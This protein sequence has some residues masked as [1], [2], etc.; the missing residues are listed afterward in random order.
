MKKRERGST[1]IL[2]MIVI[3]VLAMCVAGALDYTLQTFRDAQQTNALNQAIAAGNGA[4]DLAYVQWREAC[5]SQENTAMTAA[6][7]SSWVY[8]PTYS[9]LVGSSATAGSFLNFSGTAVP[10]TVTVSSLNATNPATIN[11]PLPSSAA[12][13]PSQAQSP[14][15]P[16]YSY[17][18]K[19]VVTYQSLTG[20]QTVN[21]CRI[22]EKST[23][24]PW[25]YAIFYNGD[26]EINPGSTFNINGWVQTN[27]SLYT[28]GGG[29]GSNNLDFTN[30]VNY[31]QSWNS[32][33]QWSPSDTDHSGTPTSPS[34]TTKP[35]PGP[36][37]LPENA[38]L[39]TTASTN[40]NLADG[41]HE[42]IE[43]PVAGY[44]DPLASTDPTH[45][46]ERYYN[47][48][49]VK[50][51]ITTGTS[52]ATTN[53]QILNYAGTQVTAHSTGSDLALYNTFNNAITTNQTL[54]D[55]REGTSVTLTQLDVSKIEPNL[56]TGGSLNPATP[57]APSN[58]NLVYIEDTT[59]N[60][61]GPAN[62]G[63]ELVNGYQLPQGGLTV[64]SENPV[65]IQGDY[66]TSN[67]AAGVSSVPS[68][69]ASS[70]PLVPQAPGYVRQP[71]AVMG[72]AV[73]I[74]SNS[75]NNSSAMDSLP[76]A[77]STT[78]NTA[79]LSG[80]VIAA[81]SGSGQTFTYSG[82][83]ENFLRFLE[84]WSGKTLT[85]YGSMAQMFNSEE[86]T[87]VLAAYRELL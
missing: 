70:N 15:M 33:G 41:Y 31:A 45:P 79:I 8:P 76:N 62:R 69:A 78:I 35:S 67:T 20:L 73:T 14:T 43:P 12:P 74:L 11:N 46:S 86:A 40:P 52:V 84:N 16:S 29:S 2:S 83:A 80:N 24:S 28:G 85:Y 13:I 68:N 44:A 3:A 81:K 60:Q 65:Y 30:T 75:W 50:I 17:L 87:G 27:G 71:A 6:S 5:R 39:L 1:I 55:G 42:I 77:S 4:L 66:N 9:S 61:N 56:T 47:Q 72:D 21:V 26:L 23:Q 32:S 49:G 63:V 37:Q 7:I 18:A 36:E 19:A 82:G 25:L 53:V 34:W 58:A 64:V 22:F 57:G 48:A 10:V 59:A 54:Q 38:E 51:I